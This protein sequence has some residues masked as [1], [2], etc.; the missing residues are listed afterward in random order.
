MVSTITVSNAAQFISAVA[1]AGSGDTILMAGGDYGTM[2]L[3]SATAFG[4]GFASPVTIAAAD[5]GNP[6]VFSG[7]DLRSASNLTFRDVTFDYTFKPG[8]SLQIRPFQV[9]QG[10]SNV[11]F[12]GCTFDGDTA[13]GVSASADG[14][15]YGIGLSIRN[16]TGIRIEDCELSGFWKGAVIADSNKVVVS[17]NDI[18]SMRM[19]GLNFVAVQGVVIEDNHIHDFKTSSTSGDHNDMIQF[20][21]NGS[22]RPSTDVVIRNNHL[23]I[24]EGGFTQSIFMRNEEVDTGRAGSSMFYRNV[25]IEDNVIVNGHL[26]GISVGETAGLVIRSNSVLHA[27]GNRPDGADAA[28]EIP[29]IAVADRSTGVTIVQNVTSAIDVP[30][31]KAGWTVAKNVIVQDQNAFAEG[32]YGDVFVASSLDFEGGRHN[33]VALPGGAI[34]RLDAGAKATLSPPATTLDAAFHMGSPLPGGQ[35]RSFDASVTL[36][37]Q[38]AGT[39]YLWS[40]GDGTTASGKT[41]TH[42]FAKGG[43]YD[44]TLTVRLPDGRSDRAFLSVP[45]DGRDLVRLADSGAFAVFSAGTE[46]LLARAAAGST[47]GLQLGAAG[48][49]ASVGKG[50]LLR[51]F[52]A[53]TVEMSF[54]LDPERAGTTGEI[55]R[56]H[57]SF[58]LSVDGSGQLAMRA[59]SSE[60][61]AV[62]LVSKGVVINRGPAHDI[63]VLLR[64]GQLSLWVDGRKTDEVAFDGTFA[65]LGNNGLTFGNPWGQRNVAA[66]ITEFAIELT[67]GGAAPAPAQPQARQGE[68]VLRLDESGAFAV[69]ENGEE[70]LLARVPSDGG[71]LDMGGTAPVTSVARSHLEPLFKTEDVTISMRLDAETAG[72]TGEIV[73][74]QG[75]FILQV[76]VRGELLL[77]AWSSE[78]D[79][80]TLVSTGVRVNRGAEHEVEIRL[81]A[82]QLSLWVDGAKTAERAFDGAFAD[83]GNHALMFGTPWGHR[84]VDAD[85][86]AFQVVID[87]GPGSHAF[88]NDAFS[89]AAAMD[90][91]SPLM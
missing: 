64:D 86:S 53:K 36:G 12:S 43:E 7:L 5:P 27:D 63:E 16:S 20:W 58:I 23:D 9:G 70:T 11:T 89:L 47:D 22:T 62:A 88:Q 75:S 69:F 74:L 46:T 6:P 44:V 19:D 34:D 4:K 37:P 15:G 1:R 49:A 76:D 40:F 50:H 28:V 60:G 26:H 38:P 48:V 78:G 32:W 56:V 54:T 55:L 31:G 82:G 59:W 10:S 79:A 33:F 3:H 21:T 45:V 30:A 29:R 85:I 52:E 83:T 73:R 25:L 81:D 42:T 84:Q 66:D 90:G 91:A 2:F 17:S 72:T 71:A 24:G 77:R 87:D 35:V 18:H 65:S 57:G 39:T 13:K 80:V 51:L 14:F 68:D 8:D 41:V 67:G 61:D